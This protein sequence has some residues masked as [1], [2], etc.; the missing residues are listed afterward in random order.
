[1]NLR[2][3][4]VSFNLHAVNLRVLMIS[5]CRKLIINFII[6]SNLLSEFFKSL[7]NG[8]AYVHTLTQLPVTFDV[9]AVFKIMFYEL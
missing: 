1:M 7:G 8:L 6:R 2:K 3:A 5:I 9:F 4:L